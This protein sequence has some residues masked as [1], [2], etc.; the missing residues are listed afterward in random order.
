[1]TAAASKTL[2]GDAESG[3]AVAAADVAIGTVHVEGWGFWS[4]GMAPKFRDAV[5]SACV[6]PTK[7]TRVEMELMRLKPL[8]EEGEEAWLQVL[9]RLPG[10]GIRAIVVATNSLTKL[11]L[12]R[13]ARLS[14]SKDMI[15]FVNMGRR[16]QEEDT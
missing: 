13:L 11:Q 4:I 2:G 15:E 10:H 14:A 3:F 5:L 8:R 1:M 16:H 6:G 12:L 9:A 7:A